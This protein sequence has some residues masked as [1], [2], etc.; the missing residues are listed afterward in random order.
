MCVDV[1]CGTL[2][3][4]SF[5]LFKLGCTVHQRRPKIEKVTVSGSLSPYDTS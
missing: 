5:F 3:V 4:V 2:A 1:Q